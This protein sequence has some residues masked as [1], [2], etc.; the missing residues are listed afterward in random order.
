MSEENNENKIAIV[1]NNYLAKVSKTLSITNKLL[2]E[3]NSR[4]SVPSDDFRVAIPDVNFQK[5][6]TEK[7]GIVVTEGTVAYGDVKNVTKIECENSLIE[8]LLGLEYFINLINLNCYDNQLT[9]L[10]VTKNTALDDLRCYRNKLTSLN[11]SKNTVLTNLSCYS[12]KLT[13]LDVSKNTDLLNLSCHWN[14][15]TSLDVSKNNALTYLSCSG[16]SF[17]C[18][19][20]KRKYGIVI[21]NKGF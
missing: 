17:D 3:I 8:S 2:N 7:L 14:K 5:Y 4:S 1:K 15:L 12:N 6:L 13:S 16:N 10:D 11:V 9:S 18:D 19:A 21:E 20:L